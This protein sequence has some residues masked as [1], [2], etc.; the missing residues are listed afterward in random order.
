MPKQLLHHLEFGSDTSL[1]FLGSENEAQEIAELL[2][3]DFLRGVVC[4]YAV[5]N[6]KIQ[7][8]NDRNKRAKTAAAKEKIPASFPAR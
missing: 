5:H 2:E 8:E 3:R 7:S 6:D 4:I 1:L